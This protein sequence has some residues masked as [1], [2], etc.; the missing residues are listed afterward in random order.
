MS[1]VVGGREAPLSCILAC[2]LTKQI[3]PRVARMQLFC[4]SKLVHVDFMAFLLLFL[5]SSMR[6]KSDILSTFVQGNDLNNH[7][8][9]RFIHSIIFHFCCQQV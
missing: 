3:P 2:P 4:I 8:R 9:S 6:V 1:N 5:L 7:K